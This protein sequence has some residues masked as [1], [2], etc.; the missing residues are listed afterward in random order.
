M[1]YPLLIGI[2]FAA[3]P[4]VDAWGQGGRGGAEL[5]RVMRWVRTRKFDSI[6]SID[7]PV[8][9]GADSARSFLRPL[10]PVV[11]L[12]GAGVAKA[13]P[14]A[15]LNGREVVNDSLGNGPIT[16]TW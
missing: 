7:R 3:S 4:T 6:A 11:G 9:V 10:D 12:S 2:L 13:Y 5:E 14:V 16:V 1:W 15:F 8:F